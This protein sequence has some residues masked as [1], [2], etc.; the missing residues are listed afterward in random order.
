MFGSERPSPES[1][2]SAQLMGASIAA[3]LAAA[4]RATLSRQGAY[5]PLFNQEGNT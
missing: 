5:G 1:A 2:E 4:P 3:R